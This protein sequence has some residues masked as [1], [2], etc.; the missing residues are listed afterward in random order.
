L[1]ALMAAR[2]AVHAGGVL[3]VVDRQRA[4]YPPAAAR[5][6]MDLQNT[7]AVFPDHEKD[8][9]WA[10]DQAL[11]CPHVAAVLAWP[12][13]LDARTFRRLQLV[14]EQSGAVGLFVRDAAARNEPSWADVR[15][16]VSPQSS[17]HTPCTATGSG[18]CLRVELLH[19]RGGFANG[20]VEWA[21]DE[22]SGNTAAGFMNRGTGWVG[23]QDADV[24]HVV[25]KLASPT[26][27]AYSA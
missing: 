8:E 22:Y 3:V 16:M 9:H 20:R 13:R 5:W 17:Q 10:L 15:L 23:D 6:G 1:L 2:E 11:R 26:V 18:W 14:A 12:R 27:G 4:F 21:I 25:T 24:G 19:C 7:L